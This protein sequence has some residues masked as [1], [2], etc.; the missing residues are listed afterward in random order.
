MSVTISQETPLQ[1]DVRAMIAE[2]DAA[3][4]EQEPDTPDEFN[5]PMTAEEMAG[6]EMTVFVA[7]SGGEA[8]GCCAVREMGEGLAEVKR[9]YVRTAARGTGLAARLI[10]TVEAHAR[11]AGFSR[12]AL[13]TGLD[14][15]AARKAYE[16][17]GF[18]RCGAFGDYPDNPYC[19][20]Y[21]KL[22]VPAA[23]TPDHTPD[24]E[25]TR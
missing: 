8:L 10:A 19:A 4:R 20:F 14:Y 16:R 12:L 15:H 2:L 25:A 24:F 18:Q 1:D 6:P 7:R 13:E 5:F 22:L 23:R 17:A 21:E 3:M 11:E 9:L